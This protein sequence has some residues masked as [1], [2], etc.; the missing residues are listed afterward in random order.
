MKELRKT[1]NVG[2]LLSP[3]VTDEK[4]FDPASITRKHSLK[5]GRLANSNPSHMGFAE[6]SVI[7]LADV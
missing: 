1:K 4:G 6:Q 7:R 3:S 2:T 5:L